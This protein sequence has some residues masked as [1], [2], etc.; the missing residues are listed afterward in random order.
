MGSKSASFHREWW[1]HMQREVLIPYNVVHCALTHTSR[2]TSVI[3]L[4]PIF[5]SSSSHLVIH[6]PISNMKYYL[7]RSQSPAM[8]SWQGITRDLRDS[9][10]RTVRNNSETNAYTIVSRIIPS[11]H[12]YMQS[13]DCSGCSCASYEDLCSKTFSSRYMGN[14]RIAVAIVS[15]LER[16]NSFL[17]L[18]LRLIF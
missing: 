4:S 11:T 3:L 14:V 5:I 18:G 1:K 8:T 2:C 9:C 10:N 6:N 13:S 17:S 16:R 7:F 12:T 15:V